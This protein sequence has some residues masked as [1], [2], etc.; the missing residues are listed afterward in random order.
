MDVTA[1]MPT[2]ASSL[3]H[4]AT[5]SMPTAP[6][7]RLVMP[8]APRSRLLVSLQGP[9]RAYGKQGARQPDEGRESLLR[10]GVRVCLHICVWKGISPSKVQVPLGIVAKCHPSPTDRHESILGKG[11][12]GRG[13]PGGGDAVPACAPAQDGTP[14]GTSSR[15]E[16]AT[17]PPSGLGGRRSPGPVACLGASTQRVRPSGRA[18]RSAIASPVE[19]PADLPAD[20]EMRRIAVLLVRASAKAREVE[21]NGIAIDPSEEAVYVPRARGMTVSGLP[22]GRNGTFGQRELSAWALP[23]IPEGWSLTWRGISTSPCLGCPGTEGSSRLIRSSKWI[24]RGTGAC[25]STTR[26]GTSEAGPPSRGAR[27]A[28]MPRDR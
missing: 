14:D 21:N 8:R 4:R 25:S 1:A 6:C 17:H 23:A 2:Y 7:V 20:L 10:R 3:L 5:E 19:A 28:G 26:L 11:G 22:S 13:T 12:Q 9:R 27:H 15:P 16:P 24:E 18:R